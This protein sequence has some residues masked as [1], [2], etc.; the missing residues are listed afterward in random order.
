LCEGKYPILEI[1]N[2]TKQFLLEDGLKI[3]AVDNV[4]LKL[5]AGEC[6]GIV[7]ESGCG[8]STLAKI[9]THL[10]SITSGFILY[11]GKDIT[12]LR[13]EKLRQNR[14]RIQ[15]IFQD[16][17]AAFNPRM[18]VSDIVSEPILNFKLM[19]KQAA[20]E[21]VKK[22][23][24]VVGLTGDF[25]DRFSHQ[26]SGG[27]RQ[28]VAIARA[29]SVKPEIIIY[30]EATSALDVSVQA[31][32]LQLLADLQRKQ[33]LTYIFIGHDLAV[34]RNV[35]C[36]IVVMYLGRIVEIIDSEKLSLDAVHPYTRALL[37]SVFFV[38][39]DNQHEFEII[40]GDSSN[41]GNVNSGCDFY[42]RC[43][44]RKDMCS[45]KEPELRKVG[46]NHF[47]ACH[48]RGAGQ[49]E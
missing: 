16:S 33:K 22:L 1:K 32:V 13:G 40:D 8:K 26:L 7:G 14:R 45:L 19:K 18:R 10:E 30:D 31:Q 49:R 20:M 27:E 35:S 39:K 21:E 41:L 44:H 36:R 28:R 34:V 42:F 6:L 46:N 24:A 29:L 25:M 9:I 4:S 3:T 37:A 15:M 48:L 5:H 12:G 2:I 23:M 47:V 38:T 17:A 43:K 11:N